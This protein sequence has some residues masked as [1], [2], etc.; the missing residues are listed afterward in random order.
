MRHAHQ[1]L[2]TTPRLALCVAALAGLAA[3]HRATEPTAGQLTEA[4]HAYL[5]QRGN[6]CLAKNT[7]PIDV[8]QHDVDV[9]AR[10]ALQMPVLERLGLVESGVAQV[11]V[12]DEGARHAMKVRRYALTEAGRKFYIARPAGVAAPQRDFCAASLSLDR[13]VGWNVSPPAGS[14]PRQAVVTYTYRVDAAPWTHDAQVQ[15]VF[16]VVAGVVRGAG[17]SE[18]QET[19]TLTEAGWVAVDLQGT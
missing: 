18:L 16:P 13:I 9:G 3:C 4:M 15:A 6:L 5:A 1:L 8:T 19:F 14:A 12:D 17:K 10:N 11:E 7:W 2:K